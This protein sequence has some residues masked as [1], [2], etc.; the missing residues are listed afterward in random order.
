MRFKAV[1][2][3][4][5]SEWDHTVR[6]MGGTIFHSSI[7]ADH[8]CITEPGAIPVFCSLVAENGKQIGIAL[9]FRFRSKH[10]VIATM[11]SRFRTDAL[12]IVKQ[13]NVDCFAEFVQALETHTRAAGDVE[14]T[15]GS[16]ASGRHGDMLTNLGFTSTRRLEFEI[17]LDRSDDELWMN[18]E[19]KRR[20]NIKKAMRLEVK[21]E[22][23]PFE[24]GIAALRRLQGASAHRI[25]QRG[26]PDITYHG[27]ATVDPI[28]PLVKAG[29]GRLIGAIVADTIVSASLFTCFNNLVYHTLSGHGP[30]ALETQA[31]TLL[32]WETMKRYRNEGATRLN[33]G[34][35]SI[36]ALNENSPEHGVYIYKVAFGGECLECVSGTKILR[37]GVHQVMKTARLLLRR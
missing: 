2:Q 18:F 1:D 34:G 13:N 3:V 8:I 31:P 33:L 17:P 11:T 27:L 24:E 25:V 7:W 19:Y 21:I 14:L 5:R 26:G 16:F 15:L 30:Q 22:D 35:C 12:P 23:L 36:D 37:R 4:E 29:V 20:K 10:R 6:D 9:G 32:L 28:T